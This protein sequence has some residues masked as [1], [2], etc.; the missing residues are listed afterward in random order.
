MTAHR[1][2]QRRARQQPGL[3]HCGLGHQYSFRG[4]AATRSTTTASAEAGG[5][6]QLG[7]AGHQD[8]DAAL[9]ASSVAAA[10]GHTEHAVE[11]PRCPWTP[12]AKPWRLLLR[13]AKSTFGTASGGRGLASPACMRQP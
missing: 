13:V 12:G 4:A 11:F 6:V 2:G 8:L 9:A 5:S 10:A 1:D 3:R 7:R